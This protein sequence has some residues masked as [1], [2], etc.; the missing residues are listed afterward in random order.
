MGWP[1]RTMQLGSIKQSSDGGEITVV[2]ANDVLSS[3]D[4]EIIALSLQN[5]NVRR[6]Q[7]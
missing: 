4:N 2:E 7:L 5:P 6:R 1:S 3:T